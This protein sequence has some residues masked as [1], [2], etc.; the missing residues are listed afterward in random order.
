MK[1]KLKD[2]EKKRKN[3]CYKAQKLLS[4][5]LGCVLRNSSHINALKGDDKIQYFPYDCFI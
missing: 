5:I 1:S 2:E 3:D 4:Y